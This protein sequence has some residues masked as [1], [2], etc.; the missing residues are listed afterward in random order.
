MLKFCSQNNEADACFGQVVDKFKMIDQLVK[1]GRNEGGNTPRRTTRNKSSGGPPSKDSL[2]Y[3]AG[4]TPAAVADLDLNRSSPQ[5]EEVE[6]DDN[7]FVEIDTRKR[8]LKT[9]TSSSKKRP[10]RPEEKKGDGPADDLA[11]D[12]HFARSVD[13]VLLS[14]S[15]SLQ[16]S[17][18]RPR[19]SRCRS[20]DDDAII[21]SL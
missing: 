3:V 1:S 15:N 13:D 21:V 16:R 5:V 17:T 9:L 20:D 14:A 12:D 6:D 19:Y 18:E 10:K 11:D 2:W 4:N 8:P 7:D